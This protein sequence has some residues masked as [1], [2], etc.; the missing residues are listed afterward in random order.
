[1]FRLIP[2]TGKKHQL[3]LH[4]SNLGFPIVNDPL[5]PVQT[6]TQPD[7]FSK[8]MQLAAKY[9]RFIDPVSNKPVEFVSG[10][11]LKL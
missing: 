4:M 5:Y 2:V 1:M 8:P 9:L 11:D 10:C 6:R 7:D 3:R